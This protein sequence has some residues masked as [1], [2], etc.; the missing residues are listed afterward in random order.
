[1]THIKLIEAA[2]QL[3][4]AWASQCIGAVGTAKLKLIC[5]NATAYP[6]ECHDYAEGLLVL[7][8]HMMLSVEG[9]AVRVGRG[10]MYLV[11]AGVRHSV[12]AGSYGTLLILDE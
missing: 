7:D 1:M 12:D 10:E 5:M 9:Q 8:G 3:P 6:E 11:P 4:Q 2:G